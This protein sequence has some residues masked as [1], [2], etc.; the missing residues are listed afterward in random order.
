[1][2]PPGFKLVVVLKIPIY[3]VPTVM[4][5]VHKEKLKILHTTCRRKLV[6]V[7][8]G[9]VKRIIIVFNTIAIAIVIINA[10]FMIVFTSCFIPNNKSKPRSE[11]GRFGHLPDKPVPTNW[12]RLPFPRDTP[13]F[14]ISARSKLCAREG[15]GA[16]MVREM[17]VPRENP[18]ATCIICHISHVLKIWVLNPLGIKSRSLWLEVSGLITT[19]LWQPYMHRGLQDRVHHCTKCVWRGA[20]MKGRG[21]RE[22]PRENPPI[23]GIVPRVKRWEGCVAGGRVTDK[24]HERARG[25]S[26]PGGLERNCRRGGPR[27]MKVA[28]L[29]QSLSSHGRWRSSRRSRAKRVAWYSSR[30]HHVIVNND[31]KQI[32]AVDGLTGLFAE[33]VKSSHTMSRRK[34]SNPKPLKPHSR[35]RRLLSVGACG[36]DGSAYRRPSFQDVAPRA[37]RGIVSGRYLLAEDVDGR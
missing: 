28:T 12:S 24:R 13:V 26:A 1:M 29:R 36:W 10:V 7:T 2:V 34:Q 18:P 30:V 4:E 19:P 17:G 21:K 15:D 20:G 23:N 14:T 27:Q 31:N 37:A 35:G 16:A 6:G 32:A 8:C 25:G 3:V 22:F 5:S 11:K 9:N 33:L